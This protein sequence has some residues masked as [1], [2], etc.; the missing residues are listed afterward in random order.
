MHGSCS[1]AP[2]PCRPRPWCWRGG[3][4]TFVL[5]GHRRGGPGLC[6]RD[7]PLPGAGGAHAVFSLPPAEL[8]FS[9]DATHFLIASLGSSAV[10]AQIRQV[11]RADA[12]VLLRHGS[13]IKGLFNYPVEPAEL[14]G[15]RVCAERSASRCRHPD[16][17]E[18]RSMNAADESLGNVLLVGLGAVAIQVA[19]D[20]RRHGAGRLGALNHPGRRSQRIAEAPARRLPATG[21]AGAASLA[22]RQ[23]RAGRLPPGPR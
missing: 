2:V 6:P 17:G 4:R 14:E 21:R 23:R 12:K 1:S 3:R 7:R 19:L 8:A 13:G 9:R 15:W 16:P 10:L 11:M 22:V 5:P 20:L 18:G